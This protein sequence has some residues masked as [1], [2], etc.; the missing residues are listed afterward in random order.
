MRRTIHE[1]EMALFSE[2]MQSCVQI[3]LDIAD[4]VRD[5]DISSVNQGTGR[6]KSMTMT[7]FCSGPGV[8]SNTGYSSTRDPWLCS[9]VALVAKIEGSTAEVRIRGSVPARVTRD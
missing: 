9:H 7:R 5:R 8:A 2:C 1:S 3:V 6:Y 4:I